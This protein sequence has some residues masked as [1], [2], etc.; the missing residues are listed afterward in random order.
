MQNLNNNED[1]NDLD[2]VFVH[3]ETE[4]K[5][6]LALSMFQKYQSSS[7]WLVLILVIAMCY[8]WQ[9][10]REHFPEEGFTLFHGNNQIVYQGTSLYFHYF[11]GNLELFHAPEDKG[12]EKVITYQ[13][14]FHDQIRS[15]EEKEFVPLE[16]VDYYLIAQTAFFPYNSPVI[17]SFNTMILNYSWFIFFLAGIMF[18]FAP[19]LGI[20]LMAPL[21][22]WIVRGKGIQEVKYDAEEKYWIGGL[23]FFACSFALFIRQN[24]V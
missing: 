15:E 2:S 7:V 4:F 16:G 20:F 9:Q 10:R 23:I 19:R 22:F 8:L 6:T 21:G 11:G 12:S 24:I 18:T 5:D 1:R 3:R 17:P 14:W 13:L